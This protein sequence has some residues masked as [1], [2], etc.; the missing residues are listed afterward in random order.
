[1]IDLPRTATGNDGDPGQTEAPSP[2]GAAD[3]PPPAPPGYQLLDEVGSGGM[4]VVYRARELALNRHVAVKVLHGRFPAD[5]APP[6]GSLRR[7]RSPASSSTQASRRSTR[8]A[9]SP[10]AGRSW[11]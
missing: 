2:T 4:G 7:H 1:M 6:P 9:P 5:G 11:S 10:T 8:S 3:A